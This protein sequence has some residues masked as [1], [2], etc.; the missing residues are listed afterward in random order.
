MSCDFVLS[1]RT[2]K[3]IHNFSKHLQ[4]DIRIVTSGKIKRSLLSLIE[5][6]GENY[7]NGTRNLLFIAAHIQFLLHSSDVL[8]RKKF[9][10]R[11]EYFGKMKNQYFVLIFIA[12]CYSF[13]PLT[14]A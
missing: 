7:E 5:Q 3:A 13:I 6:K 10:L 12:I 4:L 1:A 2:A 14:L 11:V 9:T 8:K